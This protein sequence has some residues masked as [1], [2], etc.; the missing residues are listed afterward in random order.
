M[1]ANRIILNMKYAGII[2][3]IAEMKGIC[4]EEA[5][6]IFCKSPLFPLMIVEWLTCT[7][8]VTNIS[9]K[10]SLMTKNKK[11]RRKLLKKCITDLVVSSL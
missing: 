10:K 5:M 4:N 1:E 3:V 9:P 7:A 6:D 2:S 8:A 11:E